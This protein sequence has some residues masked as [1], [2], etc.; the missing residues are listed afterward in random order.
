MPFF[1]PLHG[2]VSGYDPAYS[3]FLLYT[4]INTNTGKQSQLAAVLFIRSL[5]LVLYFLFVLSTVYCALLID[6]RLICLAMVANENFRMRLGTRQSAPPVQS[7]QCT[8]TIPTIQQKCRSQLYSEK[9]QYYNVSS[10]LRNEQLLDLLVQV[11]LFSKS[12]LN[13][14]ILDFEQ[15]PK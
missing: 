2:R 7:T 11:L 14:S 10:P 12:C 8:K 15:Q 6:W 9:Q 4:S 3:N 13:L 5:Q 1:V